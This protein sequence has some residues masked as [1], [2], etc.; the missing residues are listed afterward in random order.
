M[1]ANLL[2]NIFQEV[3]SKLPHTIW[4]RRLSVVSKTN[5]AKTDFLVLFFL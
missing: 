3:F 2:L 5:E 4:K 1:N